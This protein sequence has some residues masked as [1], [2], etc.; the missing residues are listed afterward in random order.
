MA[1]FEA[2]VYF[3]TSDMESI[4]KIRQH[5]GMPDKMTVNY[6]CPVSLDDDELIE[7]LKE[8][9][10]KRYIDIRQVDRKIVFPKT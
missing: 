1:K 2:I 4:R 8:V 10:R 9:E 7:V 3:R 6:E 5:F